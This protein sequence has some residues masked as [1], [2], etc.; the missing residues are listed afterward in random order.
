MGRIGEVGQQRVP[1]ESTLGKSVQEQQQRAARRTCHAAVQ[2]D[3]VRQGVDG[4]L[5]GGVRHVLFLS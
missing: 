2:G 3:A 1:N 4:F 5:Y